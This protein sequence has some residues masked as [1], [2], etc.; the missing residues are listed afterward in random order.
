[1]RSCLSIY[2]LIF[3]IYK[4]LNIGECHDTK[5]ILYPLRLML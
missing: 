5:K 2:I 3:S 4:I 1:M